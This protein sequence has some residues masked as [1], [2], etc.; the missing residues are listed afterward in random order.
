MVNINRHAHAEN[1]KAIVAAASS[2]IRQGGI[3]AAS[4]GQIAAKAGLTHGAVYRHFDNKTDLAAQ[5]ITSDFD[6]IVEVLAQMKALPNGF[7]A[8]VTTYLDPSHRDHFPWGC[9]A[10]PLAAEISRV[11]P[12]I[13]AAFV[14]GLHS[15]LQALAEVIDGR[16][17]GC[18][19]PSAARAQ[20]IVALSLLVGS[21]SLARACR[22]QDVAL[23]DA[24]L[25]EA[26]SHL[27][28]SFQTAGAASGNAEDCPGTSSPPQSG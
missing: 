26:R 28:A 9:P 3:E 23:S 12:E 14:Q 8:Y 18:A 25:A 17:E 21:M 24:I 4:V 6:K 13:Q 20:A 7:G 11:E 5:I 2:V 16:E 19:M 10:A 1:R 15:N 27:L 22:A